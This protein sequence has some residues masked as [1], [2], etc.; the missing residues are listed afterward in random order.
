[1]TSWTTFPKIWNVGHAAM[2]ELWGRELQAQEK[3]DGSQFS[4]GV[5]GD[6]LRCRSKGQELVVE[7]PEKMFALAVETA[8]QL[9]S[10]LTPEWTYRGEYLQ[11][12]KH[13]HLAYGRVPEQHII[14]FDINPSE[15]AYLSYDLLQSEAARLGLECVPQLAQG[16]LTP[17]QVEALL[18]KQSVLGNVP[19][20]GVVLKP[21]QPIYGVDGKLLMAK[22]VSE[23]YREGQKAT[24]KADNPQGG[25]ILDV[26]GKALRSEARWR[27][28]VMR[29][30]EA[31]TLQNAPQ[32]IGPLLV[33]VVED[34]QAECLPQI[35]EELLKWAW[36]HLRRKAVAGLPEWYKLQLLHRTEEDI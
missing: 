35:T 15:E 16:R 28:A 30:K 24:W 12:P 5:I 4:M 7:Q 10:R 1:M 2:L 31:G 18:G 34:V 6:Q 3:I 8:K 22:H 19:I 17:T 33:S 11:K 21:L 26:L 23:A 36:P 14:L 20:E 29:L 25:D 27:K 9:A 32:D 13:G